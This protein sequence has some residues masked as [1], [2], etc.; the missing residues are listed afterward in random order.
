MSEYIGAC[1]VIKLSG[2]FDSMEHFRSFVAQWGDLG[3]HLVFSV[4][5]HGA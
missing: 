3:V 1:V 5:G 2:D 4:P